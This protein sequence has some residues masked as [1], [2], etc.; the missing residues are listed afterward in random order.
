MRWRILTV[1]RSRVMEEGHSFLDLIR[2][3]RS[4][5]PEGAEELVRRYAPAVR[6]VIR[7]QLRD[8][9][10]RRVLDTMDVC[11]SVLASFFL[12]AAAGQYDLDQPD[13][14]LRLLAVMA[15]N[16][17]AT[18][19]RHSYVVRR[20]HLPSSAEVPILSLDP[21]SG[22]DR[23]AAGRDLLR[24]V[25]DRLSAEERQL[26]DRRALFQDWNQIAAELGGTPD[27]LRK[28]LTRALDRVSRQLG[29]DE[30]NHG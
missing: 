4:G 24:A 28:K 23:H 17:L 1:R 14:L 9:R 11:Q 18:R 25:L 5:D 16:K 8:R 13:Q 26:A 30:L 21:D 29:L 15:R 10:L 27:A 22:P 2:R 6:R 3:V 12:R 19:A 7:V 20:Q